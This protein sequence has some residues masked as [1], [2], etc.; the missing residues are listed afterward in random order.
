MRKARYALAGT[1]D[2]VKAEFDALKRIDGEG[3]LEWFA[4]FFDQGAMPSERRCT[5]WNC[6]PSTSYVLSAERS[7]GVR[8]DQPRL[9]AV[10]D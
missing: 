8:P 9:W 6:L 1:V 10:A 7:A 4:W 5:R 3:D 2:Q